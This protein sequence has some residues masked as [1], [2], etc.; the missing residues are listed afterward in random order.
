VARVSSHEN[1]PW[2][3]PFVVV[4]SCINYRWANQ[5]LNN[6]KES[7]ILILKLGFFAQP[8]FFIFAH[9]F[10]IARL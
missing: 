10:I 6:N 7:G 5:A 8:H 9:H 1:V 3:L 4:Y 2:T